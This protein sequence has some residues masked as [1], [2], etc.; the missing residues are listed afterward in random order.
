MKIALINNFFPPRAGG[1]AHF[2]E[3]LAAEMTAVG[4]DVLVVTAQGQGLTEPDRV[5]PFHVERLPS[6]SMPA[7]R[8][9]FGYDLTW[10]A[11]AG[12]LRRMFRVLDK[13]GAE[14][15]HQQNQIFDLSLMSS[16]WARRRNVPVVLTIHTALIHTDRLPA[17]A[18]SGLDRAV[19]KQ[20]IRL[21][22]AHVVA[23]DIFMTE[24]VKRRYGIRGERMSNIPIGVNIHRFEGSRPGAVRAELGIGDRPMVLSLGHVI[25]LRDRLALIEA[26]PL[27][28]RAVPDV[29]VVVAGQVYDDRFLQRAR[30]LGVEDSLLVIGRVPKDDVPSLVAA[31]DL[32]CHDLQGL[33]LGTA[34]MEV[35]ATGTPVVAALREDNFPGLELLNWEDLVIVPCN[36]PSALAEALRRLLQDKELRTRIGDNGRRFVLK[37]FSMERVSEQYLE[38]YQDLI[39][40]WPRRGRWLPPRAA[41]TG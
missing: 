40:S 1:S 14:V 11:S 22:D 3:E 27:L 9:A 32:D 18:L 15:V 5:H 17:V 24:Y 7:N 41:A 36:D 23:P 6:R 39:T 19:A 2:T 21:A 31:A 13:F 38:L 28:R 29:V 16:V 26:L 25:P 10:C 8:L 4:H 35:M 12:N 33:G 37:H 34:N 30:E 20:F